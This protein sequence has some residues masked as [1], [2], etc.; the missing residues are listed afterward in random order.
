MNSTT[1]PAPAIFRHSRFVKTPVV[2][3][4][5]QLQTFQRGQWVKLAWCDKPSRFHSFKTNGRSYSVVA[6][7]FPNAA[8]GFASYCNPGDSL[9]AAHRAKALPARVKTLLTSANVM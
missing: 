1:T 2:T 4:V 8:Q 3:D 9:P 7:H 6:F 5:L